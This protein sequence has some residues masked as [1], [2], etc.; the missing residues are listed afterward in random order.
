MRQTPL[1]AHGGRPLAWSL[2]AAMACSSG[3]EELL[4]EPESDEE[5]IARAVALAEQAQGQSA[6]EASDEPHGESIDA[7][8]ARVE[9]ETPSSVRETIEAIGYDSLL[10]DSCRARVAEEE[11]SIVPCAEIEARLVRR[12]CETRVAI[13]ARDPG[14]CPSGTTGHEPLCL[15]LASRDRSLCRAAPHLERE[16]CRELLG[17]EDACTESIAPELCRSLVARHRSRLGAVAPMPEAPPATREPPE[18]VVS[19]TREVE[20]EPDAPIGEEEALTAFDR[21]ARIYVESGRTMLELADPLG[22]SVVSHAGHPSLRIALPL[23]PHDGADDARLEARIG[24]LA[25][26]VELSHPD[27]GALRADEGRVELAHLSRELGG[28][29]EGRLDV[30]CPHAPGVVRVRGHF[31]TFLRDVSGAL[32]VADPLGDLDEGE[33]Q[34]AGSTRPGQP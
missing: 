28:A 4:A 18:L 34:G 12:S 31:R 9:S 27:L 16:A 5:A 29:I 25:A 33:V 11:R 26:E 22:L 10:R 7:C 6:S 30:S 19:L 17:E 2:L 23:P 13:A 14:L 8:L 24:T 21:G 32:D 1:G 3:C 15:A 20:G